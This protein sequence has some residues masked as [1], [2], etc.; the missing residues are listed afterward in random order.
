MTFARHRSS[1][2]VPASAATSPRARAWPPVL[3]TAVVWGALALS[4]GYWGLRWWGEAP[5]R[6]LPSPQPATLNIDSGRVAA[7][8]GASAVGAAPAASAPVASLSGRLRLLGVVA[9]RGGLG[10]A[11]ISVDGQPAQPFRVGASVVD[12]VRLLSLGPRHAEVGG[13]AGQARLTLPDLVAAPTLASKLI[14]SGVI[15]P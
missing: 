12:G 14:G 4:A 15:R 5:S 8:L 7:A 2:P 1:G 10:A 6:P 13:D 11:L 3:G 9:D